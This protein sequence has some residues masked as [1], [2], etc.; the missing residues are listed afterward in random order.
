MQ[1][2]GSEF[3]V[4]LAWKR[5]MSHD[6]ETQKNTKKYICLPKEII[7]FDTCKSQN[8]SEEKKNNS[9]WPKSSAT[10]FTSLCS[11][12]STKKTFIDTV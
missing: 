3:W 10:K 9:L 1:K 6:F 5:I 4:L 12:S 8:F 7:N 2:L 11:K